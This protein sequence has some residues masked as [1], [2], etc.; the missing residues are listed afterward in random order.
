M[1]R[2][3]F[4]VN[5]RASIGVLRLAVGIFHM[6]I[7]LLGFHRPGMVDFVPGY[8]GFSAIAPTSEWAWVALLIGFG[9]LFLPRGNL[10]L[11]IWQVLSLALFAVFAMLTS[12]V[13]GVIW[14]TLAYAFPAAI[15]AIVM[16]FTAQDWVERQ[17]W[18]DA[19]QQRV[20]ISRGR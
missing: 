17:P 11:L 16:W 20:R 8:A 4:T 7:A 14:G 12:A 1:T 2:I 15:S 18:F 3:V 5:L 9:V 19:A 10:L 6:S 13:Y